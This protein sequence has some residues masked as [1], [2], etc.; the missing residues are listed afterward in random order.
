MVNA[1]YVKTSDISE[2]MY[3]TTRQ[4]GSCDGTLIADDYYTNPADLILFMAIIMLLV[5]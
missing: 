1:A 3:S 4:Y 2:G 5:Q